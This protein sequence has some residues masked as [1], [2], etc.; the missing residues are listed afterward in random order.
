MGIGEGNNR[1]KLK[2]PALKRDF[3]MEISDDKFEK[4]KY[5]A[6]KFYEHI[7]RIWCPYLG[8]EINFNSE[9]FEHLLAKSW[10]RGRSRVEQYTRLK[11]LPKVVEI[12]RS[13][14][15]LQEYDQRLVFMRRKINSRWEKQVR[16][17]RYF[18][19]IALLRNHGI[20]F[21]IIVKEAE[22]GQPFFWSVYPSWRTVT[23]ESGER[24]K[25]FFYGNLE[26]D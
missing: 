20:R 12:I 6:K 18:V 10:N 5:S 13:S 26:E 14:H 16:T 24:K 23:Q 2:S 3:C 17:V 25:I 7:G 8:R 1:L 19:F 21:K 9:G 22:G 15:T 11:I 4:A